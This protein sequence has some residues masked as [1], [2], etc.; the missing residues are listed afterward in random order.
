MEEAFA[1][2]AERVAYS[3]MGAD[4]SFAQ[5]DR[6]G[7]SLAAYLQSLGLVKGD[8][9]AVMMPNIPQYPVA[10]AGILR[11]GFVVVN[12][13]PLYT[14]R[15]LEHQ[16]KDSGAKAIVVLENFASTLEKC[17]P[18]TPVKH[19]VLCAKRSDDRLSNTTTAGLVI[20]IDKSNF[21]HSSLVAG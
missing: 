21:W 18:A 7:L 11:A 17:L 5:T 9:V 6:Q 19:I 15:E 20:R 12:V 1:Q 10:V 13:N 3:F 16:L 14:P 8:R 4:I 2:Y